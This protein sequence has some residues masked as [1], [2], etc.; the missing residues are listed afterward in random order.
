[1][2]S[3]VSLTINRVPTGQRSFS[4]MAFGSVTRPAVETVTRV[5]ATKV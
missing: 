5:T 1:M 3:L 4:R 2:P